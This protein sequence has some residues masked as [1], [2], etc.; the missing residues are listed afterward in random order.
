MERRFQE[1]IASQCAPVLMDVKPSN[2]LILTEEEEKAFLQMAPVPGISCLRLYKGTG[3]CTWLLYR[4]DALEAVLM[5]PQ[6]RTFLHT[7][8]YHPEKD[9]MEELL[10]RLADRF[11][12]YKEGKIGFPHEMGIFLGYPL[13]DVKGFIEHQG[14]DYLCSGYW[15]VYQNERKARTTFQL[16][17]TVKEKVLGMIEEGVALQEISCFAY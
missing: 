11:T 7:C 6:T 16:Y 14:R 3:K 17:R 5:W 15:K 13:A 1:T 9:T 10:E 12:S 2:L 4:A 8:D